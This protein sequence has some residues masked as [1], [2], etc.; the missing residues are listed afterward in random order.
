MNRQPTEWEKIFASYTSDK[1]LIFRIDKEH[2]K[3]NTKITNDPINKWV[4][5][6][7]RQL[8][9]EVQ[10]T[11]KHMK[12][13]SASLALKEMQI[14]TILGF[15]LTAVSMAIIKKTKEKNTSENLVRKESLLHCWYSVN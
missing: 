13:C 11:N 2:K 3:L 4:N 9:K 7:K 10:M 12:K 5:E 6:L 1:G 14:K 15:Y 8:S